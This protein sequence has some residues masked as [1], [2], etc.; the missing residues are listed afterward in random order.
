M[1]STYK[2]LGSED[3]TVVRTPIYEAIPV[4]GT[5]VSSSVY[6]TSNI[7]TYGHGM[8]QTVYDYPYLSSS[9]N[10]LFD[11]TAGRTNYE[12][13][14]IQQS[15]KRNVYNQMAQV[16]VGYDTTNAI[17]KFTVKDGGLINDDDYEN[18]FF[19]SFSR[20]LV[21]DEIKRGSF[22]M[23]LG[24]AQS[25]SSPFGSILTISD[26]NALSDTFYNDSPT[27]EY[28]VLKVTSGGS[29]TAFTEVGYVFY[30]A[31][32]VA[33]SPCVFASSGSADESTDLSG[34]Q[35][36]QLTINPAMSGT[37]G[38]T[39]VT[40]TIE[41]LFESGSIDGIAN[42]FR[43]RVQNIQF[44]NTTEIN[45]TVYFCRANHNE[46][47]YSS[48][49]TYL[50]DSGSIVVKQT[51]TDAPVSYITTVGLY[52]YDNELLAVAKLSEPIKKSPD[53]SI[54]LRVRLD[55]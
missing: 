32:V 17:K 39:I 9:A 6:G 26:T 45:S 11:I 51:S 2:R 52:S 29:N 44:N 20:L 28:G 37:N 21:K 31:G 30:Q 24:V 36:G 25:F 3:V 23:T 38:T 35:K 5:L 40:G 47:N 8:F 42:A 48:N 22:S 55:V 18:L 12:S 7:K 34:S 14:S 54:I 53:E 4:T 19:L 41:T 10:Q 16:L 50:N 33:L 13:S 49:P 27:G 15:A 43:A 46:F 1:A